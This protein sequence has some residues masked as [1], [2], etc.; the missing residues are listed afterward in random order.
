MQLLFV[1]AGV[2]D[3]IGLITVHPLRVSLK[4]YIYF[5]SLS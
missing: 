3:V 4:F 1:Q 2:V 5:F